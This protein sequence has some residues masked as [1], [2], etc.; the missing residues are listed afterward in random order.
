M[1]RKVDFKTKEK[2]GP[3][4]KAKKQKEPVFLNEAFKV[5]MQG[6]IFCLEIVPPP[7]L[8]FFC[9]HFLG[10]H[11]SPSVGGFQGGQSLP[12]EKFVGNLTTKFINLVPEKC[13]KPA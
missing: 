13:L 1:G 12:R 8:E 10:L 11:A 6:C 9:S 5:L 4:K 7:P 2:K 3:G